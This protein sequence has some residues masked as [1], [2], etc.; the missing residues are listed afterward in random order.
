LVISQLSQ[1]I[2]SS[3]NNTKEIAELSKYKDLEVEVSRIWMV[4]TK[5][6]PVIIGALE[7]I[8]KGLYQNLQMLPDQRQPYSYRRTH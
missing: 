2:N 4:R 6:V 1:N 8:K 5:I 7:T 3:N